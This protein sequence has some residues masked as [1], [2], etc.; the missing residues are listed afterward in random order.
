M[1]PQG[2]DLEILIKS[3]QLSTH[4]GRQ[5]TH[6]LPATDPQTRTFCAPK[7][8]LCTP[9]ARTNSPLDALHAVHARLRASSVHCECASGPSPCSKWGATVLPSSVRPCDASRTRPCRGLQDRGTQAPY[10][11]IGDGPGVC[12]QC[13]LNRAFSRPR[14]PVAAD[15]R[16]G[17]VLRGAG[18]HCFIVEANMPMH[19]LTCLGINGAS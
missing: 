4:C 17:G 13:M 9:D 14:L 3:M 10:I 16:C 7:F 11:Q 2:C 1:H 19:C 8:E 15:Q 18:W 5:T 6:N 12:M